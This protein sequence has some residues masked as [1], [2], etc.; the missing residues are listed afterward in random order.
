MATLFK[1]NG[2]KKPN[3]ALKDKLTCSTIISITYLFLIK[4]YPS[5]ILFKI[6]SPRILY[7]LF[8]KKKS[9]TI[10]T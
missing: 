10:I 8:K 1:Q 4:A 3:H 9:R 5:V 7:A 2:N 6:D